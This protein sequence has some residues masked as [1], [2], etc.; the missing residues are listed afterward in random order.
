MI[1]SSVIDPS[2]HNRPFPELLKEAISK[3][4]NDSIYKQVSKVITDK[5]VREAFKNWK[6]GHQDF[7]QGSPLMRKIS[8]QIDK[9]EGNNQVTKK[10][11]GFAKLK[12]TGLLA[13]EG[14]KDEEIKEEIASKEEVK[15]NSFYNEVE[16]TNIFKNTDHK[17]DT[18]Q[19]SI[20]KEYYEVGYFSD[21]EYQ[22]LLL[23]KQQQ[24]TFIRRNEIA[25][26]FI[27]QSDLLKKM[28]AYD[29]KENKSDEFNLDSRM[30][31]SYKI[32]NTWATSGKDWK[33][34][35]FSWEEMKFT[36]DQLEGL[37]KAADF[38]IIPELHNVLDNYLC[39]LLV[40]QWNKD[41]DISLKT[42]VIKLKE[43]LVDFTQKNG[44]NAA[45]DEIYDKFCDKIEANALI[46][47]ELKN[48]WCVKKAI[49]PKTYEEV[50]EKYQEV[51]NW[52]EMAI[53]FR[54][55]LTEDMLKTVL[56]D[57]FLMVD[58]QLKCHEEGSEIHKKYSKLYA[59]IFS[60]LKN[61]SSLQS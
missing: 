6:E 2:F 54:L 39:N 23:K 14:R 4:D 61:K 35:K 52:L 3:K 9:F 30:Y 41:I 58:H 37:L 46:L 34:E 24:T 33:Y 27:N 5:K 50:E 19:W 22:T 38:F 11:W 7:V 42:E 43:G 21:I 20:L 32:L 36:I 53:E 18:H 13:I 25:E 31:N 48:Q 40:N 1:S 59:H 57:G 16:T 12:Q 28:F 26:E 17:F 10:N 55:N 15:S 44:R 29:F 8:N 47:F 56:M 45:A 49:D 51:S 60:S